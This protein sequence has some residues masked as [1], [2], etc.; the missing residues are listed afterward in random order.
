[1]SSPWKSGSTMSCSES[2]INNLYIMFC[3]RNR[4]YSC[5]C[6]KGLHYQLKLSLNICEGLEFFDLS[7]T[8]SFHKKESNM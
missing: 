4:K 5:V 6:S 2:G 3:E 8:G 7:C 1:M